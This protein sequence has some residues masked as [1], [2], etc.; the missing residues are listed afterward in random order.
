VIGEATID[1]TFPNLVVLHRCLK[2]IDDVSY[3]SKNHR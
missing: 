3:A 2:S 1:E